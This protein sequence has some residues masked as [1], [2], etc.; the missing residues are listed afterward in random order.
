MNV[1]IIPFHSTEVGKQLRSILGNVISGT[2]TYLTIFEIEEYRLLGCY[3]MW[4]FQET[5]FQKNVSPPSSWLDKSVSYYYL[6]PLLRSM[7][8]L[9]VTANVVPRSSILVPLVMETIRSSDMSVFTGATRLH[10]PED[11]ILHSHRRK[12]LKFYIRDIS[13]IKSVHR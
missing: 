8:R 12:N 6:I 13:Y 11:G 7:R 5:T 10:I 1:P 4:L 3:F 9:L 2:L